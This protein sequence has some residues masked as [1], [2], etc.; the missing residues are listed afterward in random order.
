MYCMLKLDY[1]VL[2]VF[3][4]GSITYFISMIVND[5]KIFFSFLAFS[6]Y[7]TYWSPLTE[8]HNYFICKLIILLI[9]T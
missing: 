7:C 3:L 2:L 8:G 1:S 5:M 6:F 9:T 4:N